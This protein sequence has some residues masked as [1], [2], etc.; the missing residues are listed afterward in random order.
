MPRTVAAPPATASKRR[1][2]A[3]GR[4]ALSDEELHALLQ[5]MIKQCQESLGI[6]EQAGRHELASQE[7]EEIAII[8]AYLPQQMSE[9]DMRQV[10]ATVIE[11]T[12]AVGLRDIGKVMASLKQAHTGKMDFAKASALAKTLLAG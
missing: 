3:I 6:Y 5:K 12:G 11:Q 10:I 9:A 4:A 8:A 2:A 1:A 7:R